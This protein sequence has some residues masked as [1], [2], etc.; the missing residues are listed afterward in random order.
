[1]MPVLRL[2]GEDILLASYLAT[3]MF[4]LFPQ[5][6][7]EFRHGP[8]EARYLCCTTNRP[9]PCPYLIVVSSLFSC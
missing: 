1:M 7:E 9:S 3:H 5:N 2:M 8:R 6:N 4:D